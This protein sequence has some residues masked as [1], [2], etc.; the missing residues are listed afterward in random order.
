MEVLTLEVHPHVRLLAF[1]V[2][3]SND[4][5]GSNESQVKLV[6][7]RAPDPMYP[8]HKPDRRGRLTPTTLPA[9]G[10]YGEETLVNT[11]HSILLVDRVD[12]EGHE[13]I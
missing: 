1:L 2:D 7:R 5:C 4:A 12:S 13:I 8:A 3:F 9:R 6:F 10:N 11:R